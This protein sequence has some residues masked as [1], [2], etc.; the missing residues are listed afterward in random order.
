[1]IVSGASLA[2]F[3]FAAVHEPS[4]MEAT[5][6]EDM[7]KPKRAHP[8]VKPGPAEEKEQF[9]F[10]VVETPGHKRAPSGNLSTPRG[11]KC[12]SA[13]VFAPAS[14][15]KGFPGYGDYH[16]AVKLA[17]AGVATLTVATKNP[18]AKYF[19]DEDLDTLSADCVAAVEWLS[20]RIPG[21]PVGI[22]GG[23]GGGV[24]ALRAA[25]MSPTVKFVVISGMPLGAGAEFIRQPPDPKEKG[26]PL[27]PEADLA[28]DRLLANCLQITP[29][30]DLGKEGGSEELWRN[31]NVLM[32]VDPVW[33]ETQ[34][35]REE[36]F[37]S[38][39]WLDSAWAKS[40]L[41]IDTARMLRRCQVPAFVFLAETDEVVPFKPARDIA[42][43][44]LERRKASS[45]FLSCVGDG[46]GTFSS[47]AQLGR[48]GIDDAVAEW[49]S[50]GHRLT[51]TDANPRNFSIEFASPGVLR[52]EGNP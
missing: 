29:V 19:K 25:E 4:P 41:A 34:W 32:R 15:R 26:E 3:G 2:V 38:V 22:M 42:V 50:N 31:F 39:G 13:V 20:R 47:W 37:H 52:S 46:H 40:L 1:L 36:F 51:L 10:V 9:E 49:I 6:T 8:P 35:T 18:T 33:G 48:T 44:L 5:L 24:I 23:S 21:V 12:R 11:R 45:L 16:Y 28:W 43:H 7:P 30:K 14:E 17:G 27:D